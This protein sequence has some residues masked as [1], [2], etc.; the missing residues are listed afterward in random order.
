MI[1]ADA[2]ALVV[3]VR[4]HDGRYHGEP[5]W[6]PAPARLFQALVAGS[7]RTEKLEEDATRALA[8][9]EAQA[10]P[11]VAAPA[12]WSGQAVKLWVPNNDLDSQGG[13]P[14]AVSSIRTGK[15]VRPRIFDPSIPVLYI[16]MLTSADDEPHAIGV[17]EVSRDLYQLGRGIDS[18][19]ASGE[20]MAGAAVDSLL[21]GYP[22]KVNRPTP[23]AADRGLVL[24]C[25]HGGSLRSLVARHAATLQRF[26]IEGEGRHAVE[27][28]Q[29]P[30]KP[31]FA[32]VSYEGGPQ[33]ALFDLRAAESL[34]SFSPA[35]LTCV[36]ELTESLRD[37]AASRLQDALPQQRAR[38]ECGL[39]GRRVEGVPRVPAEER[40][41]IVALPS[42]GHAHV[43]R[44]VRRVLVEVPAGN[45]LRAEDVFWAFSGL[46]VAMPRGVEAIATRADDWTMLDHY[47]VRGDRGFK[48]W[49]SV[50]AVALPVARRR[51]EP[52]RRNLE[53]KGGGERASEESLARQAVLQ[54]LRHAGVRSPAVE[55]HVQREPFASKG[56]RAEAFAP[57]TRFAKELLWHVEVTFRDPVNGPLVLGDGRFLGLGIME[58]VQALPEALAFRVRSGL[59]ADASPGLVAGA[60]RRAV[61]ARCQVAIGP[62]KPLPSFVTGHGTNGAPLVDK[63]HLA[64]V[65]DEERS[66]VL[67]VVLGE[68]KKEREIGRYLPVL[69]RA[70]EG[71]SELLAG[72]AGRL[73]LAPEHLEIERDPL[74]ARSRRWISLTPY[75]VNR[76]RECGDAEQALT[77]DIEASCRAAN[78]PRASVRIVRAWGEP[79]LGLSG[80]AEITFDV[81]VAGPLLLGRTRYKGGGLFRGVEAS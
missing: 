42:I 26:R 66:R 17:C 28:F 74:W 47:G 19:S 7:A 14:A 49:R 80:M 60:M 15:Q 58:P 10:P 51:I 34:S 70:M 43:D 16:W 45:P 76:H 77:A 22:G 44:A 2:R 33:R 20:L 11:W 37:S 53:A 32:L 12:A 31:S 59:A 13:D 29:Q 46:P 63:P 25:P 57:G 72:S 62:R 30:P 50:T 81:A 73:E 1:P 65:Y 41:R 68:R 52:T 21:A 54:A 24:G 3:K 35:P 67:V 27:V 55:V 79:G 78:L 8:W 48:K 56:A 64:F 71:M 39:V 61:M 23:G 6:P 69:H 5:E 9:L 36:G 40:V 38:I 4:L 18:A 75:S